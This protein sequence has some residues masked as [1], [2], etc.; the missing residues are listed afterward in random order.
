MSNFEKIINMKN[1]KNGKQNLLKKEKE[2]SSTSEKN[3]KSQKIHVFLKK[4][5]L[6]S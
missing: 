2:K 4:Y 6:S 5:M 3:T 1:A